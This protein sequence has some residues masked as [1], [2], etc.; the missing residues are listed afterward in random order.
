MRVVC[1]GGVVYVDVCG[2]GVWCVGVCM[3][4][5]GRCGCVCAGATECLWRS[6]ESSHGPDLLLPY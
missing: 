5:G 1:E 6:E 4:V 3:Y 2:V